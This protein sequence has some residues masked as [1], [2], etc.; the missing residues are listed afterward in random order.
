MKV[1]DDK[2]NKNE[3]KVRALIVDDEFYLGQILAQALEHAGIQA[4][5]V[6]D[7]DSAINELNKQDF[8]IVISDIYLPGKTGKDFFFYTRE[9]NPELPFIFMTGNPNLEMAVDL[10]KNG[11]YDYIVKPFMIDDFVQKI[12]IT[13]QK[14]HKVKR[15]KVLVN[16]LKSLLNTRLKELRIYQDIIESTEDGLIILDTDGIIVKTNSG[17]LRMSGL[18][19]SDILHRPFSVLNRSL[20]PDLSFEEIEEKLK[21]GDSFQKE[22]S[23]FTKDQKNRI[24]NLSFF[25]IQNEQGNIFAYAALMKDVTAQRTMEKALIESLQRT[26][27][28]QEAII[29]GLARLAEHRDQDTGFHLERI[30]NYCKVFAS[31]LHHHDDFKHIVTEDFIET[32]YRTAPLHDIGKVGIPDY[33]LLKPGKLTTIEF[34]IMKSHTVIGYQTLE[35]IRRQ[36]GEMDFLNMGIE[37][38]YCHHERYDGKGYPRGLAGNEIPLSAQILS[39]ADVYDALTTERVYKDAFSHED[40]LKIMKMEQGQHFNPKLFDIFWEIADEFNVIRKKYIE[41][42]TNQYLAL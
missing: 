36:Y 3:Q 16:D 35:S 4:V 15:E 32:I 14:S 7:V 40:A 1:M 12:K 37:I 8:D 9:F 23:G 5:A 38:T 10:L 27:M 20:L 30:R 19:E 2:K 21:H 18:E 17:F 29:F 26:N 24:C 34:E 11:G 13:I 25:P 22:V 41:V 6:T 33:I 31:T 42:R 28:A 39:F